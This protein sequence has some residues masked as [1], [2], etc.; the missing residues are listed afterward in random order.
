MPI[1]SN[2]DDKNWIVSPQFDSQVENLNL[3]KFIL[4]NSEANIIPVIYEEKT[5]SIAKCHIAIGLIVDY[6]VDDSSS[7]LAL[8]R[9]VIKDLCLQC[10]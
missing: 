2:V 6:N 3:V 9:D 8:H 7:L 4:M 1:K 5:I 10:S